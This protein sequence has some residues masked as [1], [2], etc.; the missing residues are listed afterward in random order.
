M[1]ILLNG[2]ARQIAASNLGEA[3]IELGY[4][5]IGSVATAVNG[6]FIPRA[7]RLNK[8]LGEGDRI[9]VVAPMQGG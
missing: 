2:D 7:Q 6:L 9:E 3:L 8:L 1:K 5:E 4:G